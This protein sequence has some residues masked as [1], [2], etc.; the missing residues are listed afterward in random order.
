MQPGKRG[1]QRKVCTS[2][3]IDNMK[4][5]TRTKMKELHWNLLLSFDL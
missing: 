2:G 4:T 3:I 5:K 1:L